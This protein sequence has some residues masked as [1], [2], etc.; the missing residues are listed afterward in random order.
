TT[1]LGAARFAMPRARI[2]QA[3]G[4]SAEWRSETVRRYERRTTRVDDAILGV[5]LAGGNTR[6]I[7]GALAPLLRG[8]PLSKDAVSRLVGRLGE[9]FK[10]WSERDLGAE[11]ICYLVQDG[12][13][14]K[15][16]I[17]R[18]R[19]MVPVL[20]TLGVKSNGERIIVDLRLAGEESAASWGDVV[21]G[22]VRR[23]V[24]MPK[25]AMIDG[26]PGLHKALRAHWPGIAI[27]RCT[28]HKLWN[29]L[30]KAPA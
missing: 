18:Q 6:R 23:N 4:T 15:L 14:P 28:N 3:D 22:L 2:R 30:S 20:V 26:N 13:Y 8:G 10:A 29:L 1:S 16:R 11:E 7:R 25:L 21:S 24:G 5:Y 19:V 12:W 17:G 9:D 27:Q